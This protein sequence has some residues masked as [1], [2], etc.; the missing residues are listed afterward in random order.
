VGRKSLEE[1]HVLIYLVLHVHFDTDKST[2]RK[3]DIAETQKAI[4]IIKKY[5]GNNISIEGHTDSVG[6]DKYKM[7]VV[8]R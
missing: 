3:A 4:A 7:E 8:R 1:D 6:T 2:I 5:P